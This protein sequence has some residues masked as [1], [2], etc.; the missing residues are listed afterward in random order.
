MCLLCLCTDLSSKTYRVPCMV[1]HRGATST[2]PTDLDSQVEMTGM[3]RAG[4]CHLNTVHRQAHH[5]VWHKEMD[6]TVSDITGALHKI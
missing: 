3:P 2:Q 4:G 1:P 6:M 5:R